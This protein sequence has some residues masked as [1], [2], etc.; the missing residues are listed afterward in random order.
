[1][2]VIGLCGRK[3]SGKSE[4]AKICKEK[5]FVI[6]HFADALKNLVCSLLDCDR[7]QLEIIKEQAINFKVSNEKTK[8]IS[9]KLK[10]ELNIINEHL[11]DKTFVSPRE[12]L[13]FIGTDLIRKYNSDWHISEMER[14]I[15]DGENYCIDDC[16]FPNEK[17]FIEKR[18]NGK[19][20]FIIRT[21]NFDIS[22]HASET[23]LKWNDCEDII[24]NDLKLSV[25]IKKWTNYVDVLLYPEFKRANLRGFENKINF[26]N[27][28]KE[29]LQNNSTEEIAKLLNCSVDKV[30]WWANKLML[31]INRNI[32]YY[33]KN[34]F[35]YPN[36]FDAYCAGLLSADGCIKLTK[37][38]NSSLI[39]FTSTD[40][41][42]IQSLIDLYK[43]NRPPSGRIH[44]ISKK[45]FWDIDCSDSCVLENLKHWNIKPRKSQKEEVPDIIRNNEKAIKNWIVGLIDGDGT[46]TISKKKKTLKLQVLASEKIVDFINEVSPIKGYKSIHK[47][48]KLFNLTWNNYSAIDFYTWLNPKYFLPRKW[49]KI[50]DF[51]NFGTKRFIPLPDDFVKE[52]REAYCGKNK[53]QI[54]LAKEFNL[55]TTRLNNIV[56][57]KTYKNYD[58]R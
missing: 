24:V 33:N 46:I 34:A 40:Y 35:L 37:N 6:L 49:E 54:Q 10:I 4:L 30:V 17:S 57:N 39:S 52:I 21:T 8:E 47:K 7:T 25:L 14:Q 29:K 43:T 19:C 56:K 42:L 23:S 15:E 3:K 53:S 50:N 22:N 58:K 48:T 38:G 18:L 9:D 13:Q 51:L 27:W 41:E 16:R 20:Y 1:M 55:T 36:D 31:K 12:M 28:L 2:I 32:Y 26:R 5:G 44:K 11:K 45:K